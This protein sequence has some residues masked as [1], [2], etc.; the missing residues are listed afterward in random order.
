MIKIPPAN[1]DL[2]K[3]CRV[4]TYR[5]SGKGGQHV[6]K[7]DSAVRLTHL[8]TGIVSTCQ[9]ERSQ[10]RNKEIALKRLRSKLNLLNYKPKKR[11]LTNPTRASKERRMQSKKINS[12]KKS[13]RKKLNTKDEKH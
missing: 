7:T 10:F 12:Q 13:L 11:R 9:D 2:L 1:D 8:E 6:N 5:S 4:D 3:Q